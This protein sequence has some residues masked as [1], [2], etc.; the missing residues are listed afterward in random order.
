[1]STLFHQGHGLLIG[2]GGNLPCTVRDAHG[3]YDILVDPDRC[4]YPPD[5]VCLLTEEKASVENIRAELR[6]LAEAIG[7]DKQ[8]STVIVYFSGHGGYRQS[9][10]GEAYYLVASGCNEDNFH[11]TTLPGAEFTSLL[12]AIRAERLLLVLDCCHAGGIELPKTQEQK[13]KELSP[14]AGTILASKKGRVVIAS[15]TGAEFSWTGKPY[16]AFTHSLLEALCGKG[17]PRRDGFVRVGDVVTY[18]SEQVPLKTKKEQHPTFDFESEN[19]EIAY[20]AAGDTMLKSLP[21][22]S[23]EPTPTAGERP[24][25]AIPTLEVVNQ[26][27][28]RDNEGPLDVLGAELLG[29]VAVN[30]KVTNRQKMEGNTG[31]INSTGAVI[32]FRQ[33][34]RSNPSKRND[35]GE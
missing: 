11:K 20:Y 25:S 32:D 18:T 6:R 5:Q 9:S 26:D 17:N 14:Q 23:F 35:H 28:F 34:C 30:V 15:S 1:M 31:E 16:S 12:E 2:V 27:I 19:F 3:F 7:K 4:A 33:G 8:G 22:E 21:F 29:P 10:E 24:A 13:Y